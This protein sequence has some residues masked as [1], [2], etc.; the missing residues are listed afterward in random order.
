MTRV[1]LVGLA[2]ALGTLARYGVGVWAEKAFGMTFPW[3]T[4][5]VN[6]VGCFLMAFVSEVAM[7]SA[8]I[9][10]VMRLTLTTGFMGGLTTYSSFNYQTTELLRG[11]AWAAGAANLGGTLVLCLAAGVVGLVLAR[12]VTAS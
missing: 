7:E 11:K 8:S 4:L 3:G 2:G 6:V 5:I 12:R 9:S 10:P 1:L